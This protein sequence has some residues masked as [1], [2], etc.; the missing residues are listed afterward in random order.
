MKSN[1]K[2]K[3][4]VIRSKLQRDLR[5]QKVKDTSEKSPERSL[6]NSDDSLFIAREKE[7]K[8]AGH[9]KAY[10]LEYIES[11]EGSMLTIKP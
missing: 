4:S 6:Y 9:S 7:R 1:R 10:S 8:V 11:E 5:N 3:I 2:R